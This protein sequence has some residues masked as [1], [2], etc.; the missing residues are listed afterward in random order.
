MSP[1]AFTIS[2]VTGQDQICSM[3]KKHF[4]NILNCNKP[5]PGL[6]KDVLHRLKNCIS[7]DTPIMTSEIVA[8]IKSLKNDK[9]FGNDGLYSVI[10]NMDQKEYL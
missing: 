8:V 3:W 4:E 1:L 7:T 9:S 10:L 6:T 2:D 5:K